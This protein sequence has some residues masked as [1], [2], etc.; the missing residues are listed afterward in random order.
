[1][2]TQVTMDDLQVAHHEL[3]HVQYFMQYAHL[4]LTYRDG[5]NGGFHEA[6]GELVGA[7]MET[8]QHLNKVG[9]LPHPPSGPEMGVNHL[10]MAALQT[11]T[12][13]PFHLVHDLWRWRV[14][15]GEVEEDKYNEEF[16]KL[17]LEYAGVEPPVPRTDKDLDPPALFHVANNYDMI[18]YFTRTILQFQILEGLCRAAGHEGPLHTCDLHGS[19]EAGKVLASGLALGSSKPWPEVLKILTGSSNM[20]TRPLRQFFAPLEEWLK[21]K[22]LRDTGPRDTGPRDSGPRDNGQEGVGWGKD[23]RRL[24]DLINYG[25]VASAVTTTTATTTTITIL[26]LFLLIVST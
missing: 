19:E 3:G 13:L 15:R 21:D 17:M 23:W 5:A 2:C 7:M 8:P 6:I 16:W 14:W 24:N 12:T 22:G 11:V 10:M 1:M 9:L 18:R 26:L 4:P 25:G 20:S